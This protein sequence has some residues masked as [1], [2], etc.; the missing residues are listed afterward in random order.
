ML[1]RKYKIQKAQWYMWQL[2][3]GIDPTTGKQTDDSVL[4]NEQLK[5]CFRY[6][7]CVLGNMLEE[8][9]G[10]DQNYNGKKWKQRRKRKPRVLVLPDI[11]TPENIA[12]DASDKETGKTPVLLEEEGNSYE[13]RLKGKK[14]ERTITE[15]ELSCVELEE[16]GCRLYELVDNIN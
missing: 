8:M 5:K 15:T 7:Y 3:Q 13:K 4:S 10:N 9:E 11:F 12:G 14:Q 16:N 2:Q 1:D 6:I